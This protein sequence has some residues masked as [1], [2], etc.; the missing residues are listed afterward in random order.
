MIIITSELL[1]LPLY[2]F[3]YPLRGSLQN[4]F[5]GFFR[6]FVAMAALLQGASFNA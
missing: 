6:L 2:I 5:L 1:Y 4:L 3:Q